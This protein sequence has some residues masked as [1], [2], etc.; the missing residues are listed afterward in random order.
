MGVKVV[1]LVYGLIRIRKSTGMGDV[2][3]RSTKVRL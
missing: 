2:G 1:D 3:T